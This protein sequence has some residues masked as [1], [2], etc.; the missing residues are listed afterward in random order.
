M[1]REE[2]QALLH[3][4]AGAPV[5]SAYVEVI[6]DNADARFPTGRDTVT[7]RRTIGLKKVGSALAYRRSV[8]SCPRRVPTH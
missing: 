2:R 4:G 6:F 7:L 8:Q 1:T 5:I 3:E